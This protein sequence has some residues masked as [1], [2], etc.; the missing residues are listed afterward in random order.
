MNLEN[1]EVLTL[2]E[3]SSYTGLSKSHIYKLCSTGKYF[4]EFKLS[5]VISIDKSFIYSR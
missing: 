4:R 3:V 1:K 5:P 2:K